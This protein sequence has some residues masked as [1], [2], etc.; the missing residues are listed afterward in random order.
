MKMAKRA[1]P[2]TNAEL[3]DAV[4]KSV[5]EHHIWINAFTIIRPTDETLRN[6]GRVIVEYLQNRAN[7][8]P[9]WHGETEGEVGDM[10]KLTH[11][12]YLS[13]NAS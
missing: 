1:I 13:I 2:E 9:A 6:I 8:L 7:L 11:M 4:L 3:R 10:A 5:Q 12:L